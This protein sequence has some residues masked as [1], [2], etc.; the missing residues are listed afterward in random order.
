MENVFR[1]KDCSI[2]KPIHDNLKIDL[3]HDFS[4]IPRLSGSFLDVNKSK[5][6]NYI[7]PSNPFYSLHLDLSHSGYVP[8][9]DIEVEKL[10]DSVSVMDDSVVL[11]ANKRAKSQLLENSYLKLANSI[12]R[13]TQSCNYPEKPELLHPGIQ[14]PGYVTSEGSQTIEIET[15]NEI[16]S[17]PL[18]YSYVDQLWS[19]RRREQEQLFVFGEEKGDS[20]GDS[21]ALSPMSTAPSSPGF[22]IRIDGAYSSSTTPGLYSFGRGRRTGARKRF[23]IDRLTA[24][25]PSTP[26]NNLALPCFLSGSVKGIDANFNQDIVILDNQCGMYFIGL[27]ERPDKVRVRIHKDGVIT[28]IDLMESMNARFISFKE[29][30]IMHPDGS[31]ERARLSSD[32]ASIVFEKIG[33]WTAVKSDIDGEPSLP[34][35]E[36]QGCIIDS[37]FHEL[38]IITEDGGSPCL[39]PSTADKVSTISLNIDHTKINDTYSFRD[40]DVTSSH[41]QPSLEFI[42]IPPRHCLSGCNL[43]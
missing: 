1:G 21:T 22:S 33:V 20:K 3:K 4:F 8:A 5:S 12:V 6:S 39:A 10:E 18:D 14:M 31:T 29:I 36:S 16:M 30:D 28:S 17:R 43:M 34:L 24:S 42:S 32:G 13:K 38:D 27:W 19:T 9:S 11:P 37:N 15:P 25:S 23:F 2:D 7:L 40:A 35:V 41:D 26:A